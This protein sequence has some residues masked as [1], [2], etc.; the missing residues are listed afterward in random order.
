MKNILITGIC[1]LATLTT[2][3]QLAG[4]WVA[5]D[6]EDGEE[7][8]IVEIYEKNGKYEGRVF[9]L[10]PDAT[11]TH[12]T[13]CDGDLKNKSIEGMVIVTDLKKC[14]TG[15]KDGQILDPATGKWYSC[16]FELQG[17]D[18]VKMRGYLGMPTFGKSQYWYR[19]K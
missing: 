9:K 12:C 7:K 14:D 4:K 8:S 15:G 1:L 11:I 10:L 2:H 19:Q 18:K 5:V 13:G 3:A 6:H 17:N 16:Y